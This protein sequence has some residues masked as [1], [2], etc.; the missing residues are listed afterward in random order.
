M[1]SKLISI[2]YISFQ[3]IILKDLRLNHDIVIA[4]SDKGVGTVV[5]NLKQHICDT[6]IHLLDK[7]TEA[8][9]QPI[10]KKRNPGLV[11]RI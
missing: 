5:I 3:G 11:T 2:S 1:T 8:L 7:E 9:P 4:N 6:L 10:L